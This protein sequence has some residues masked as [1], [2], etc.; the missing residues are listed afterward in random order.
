MI[1]KQTK[2]FSPR[3]DLTKVVLLPEELHH[4]LKVEATERKMTLTDYVISLLAKSRGI[5]TSPCSI[6]N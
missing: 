4:Q 1:N 3:N 5:K 2:K 6:A